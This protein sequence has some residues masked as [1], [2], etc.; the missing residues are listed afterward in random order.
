MKHGRLLSSLIV[1]S[2]ICIL[3]VLLNLLTM[4]RESTLLWTIGHRFQ[5]PVKL[6]GVSMLLTM[7]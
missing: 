6:S 4:V 3:V 2:F 5:I 7:V 1:V